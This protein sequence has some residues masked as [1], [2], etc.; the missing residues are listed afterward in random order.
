[1]KPIPISTKPSKTLFDGAIS[2]PNVINFWVGAPNSSLLD[3]SL[4]CESLVERVQGDPEAH[5]ILQYGKGVIKRLD[6]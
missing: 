3:T 5:T 6:M 1:M 2:D 4:L